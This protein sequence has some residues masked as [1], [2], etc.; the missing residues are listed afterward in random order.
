MPL[1]TKFC[2]CEDCHFD[3][4]VESYYMP[5]PERF[6]CK[7]CG[8]DADIFGEN[9]YDGLEKMALN[10]IH[11]NHYDCLLRIHIISLRRLSGEDMFFVTWSKIFRVAVEAHTPKLAR[12]VLYSM[13]MHEF[14]CHEKRDD[15]DKHK[16]LELPSWMLELLIDSDYQD[17]IV[18]AINTRYYSFSEDVVAQSNGLYALCAEKGCTKFIGYMLA[19]DVVPC[20]FD[21][22]MSCTRAAAGGHLDC[23]YLLRSAKFEWDED[24]AHAAYIYGHTTC[25]LYLLKND[26]PFTIEGVSRD[27]II[28]QYA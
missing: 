1:H 5:L 19:H 9:Y 16:V 21:K 14:T 7:E 3:G 18:D 8:S 24:T 28:K 11:F 13:R 20:D 2:F 26:C 4:D 23:L 27:D 22:T 6:H 17:V 12:F 10:A 15:A 25:L